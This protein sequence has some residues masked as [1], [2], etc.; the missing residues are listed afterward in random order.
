P[1]PV[2]E[3]VGHALLEDAVTLHAL[4][5]ALEVER[6]V[7][8]MRQHRGRDGLV[9]AGEVGLCRAVSEQALVR[10]RDLDAHWGLSTHG[11]PAHAGEAVRSRGVDDARRTP[12]E[13]LLPREGAPTSLSRRSSQTPRSVEAYLEA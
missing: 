9:V 1:D 8:E 10:L 6:A 5:V 4:G 3:V 2:R 12:V 7:L 13:R 11:A